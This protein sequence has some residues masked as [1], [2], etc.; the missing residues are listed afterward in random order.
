MYKS[1]L[2]AA[3]CRVWNL[4]EGANRYFMSGEDLTVQAGLALQQD[5]AL[6]S[7][8]GLRHVERN[9][10]HYVNGMAALPAAEQH[11]F[12]RAHDDLYEHSHGAVRVRIAHGELQIRSLAVPG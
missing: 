4:E 7:L 9:G 12:L 5:L 1:L 11:A 2:N 6:V 8:L 3:R 10:H